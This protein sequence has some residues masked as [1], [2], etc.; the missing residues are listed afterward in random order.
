MSHAQ[1]H[2]SQALLRQQDNLILRDSEGHVTVHKRIS[3]E[4][5][6]KLLFLGKQLQ[7]GLITRSSQVR[8]YLYCSD[9]KL[10]CME[11]H[12]M[13]VS[14]IFQNTSEIQPPGFA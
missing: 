7:F 8:Q 10:S 5:R 3:S 13:P 2:L 12:N 4:R 6:Y 1:S 11:L 14:D 9:G